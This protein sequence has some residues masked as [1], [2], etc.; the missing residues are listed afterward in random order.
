MNFTHTYV[1]SNVRYLLPSWAFERGCKIM[2]NKTQFLMDRWS[3]FI[4]FGGTREKKPK[5]HTNHLSRLHAPEKGCPFQDD[6]CTMQ[7]GVHTPLLRR[8]NPSNTALLSGQTGTG[9]AAGACHWNIQ[10]LQITLG[11]ETQLGQEF[12]RMWW[13]LLTIRELKLKKS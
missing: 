2:V 1:R 6:P 4:S 5:I 11:C 12:S 8:L 13:V 7:L 10:P 9:Y 3:N